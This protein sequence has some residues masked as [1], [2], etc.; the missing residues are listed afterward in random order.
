[1]TKDPDSEMNEK[2]DDGARRAL[3]K[4]FD[5]AECFP[6]PRPVDRDELLKDVEKL[7]WN[8]LRPEF[9]EEYTIL[10]RR[11]YKGTAKERRLSN[12]IIT[13]DVMAAMISKYAEAISARNGIITELSQCKRSEQK[14]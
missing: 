10:E 2:L 14:R 8:E 3:K 13:G 5:T 12:R 11:L 7:D 6:L 9:R 4:C 1:M